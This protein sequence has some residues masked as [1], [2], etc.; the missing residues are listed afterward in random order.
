MLT[1]ARLR[2]VPHTPEQFDAYAGFWGKDP[3]HFLRSLAPMRPEDA[4]T[5]LLRHYGHW[6]AF[7]YG[8]FLGYDENDVLVAEVGFVDFRRAV[9][10]RFDGVPEAMWKIDLGRQGQGLAT[11]AMAAIAPWYDA[12]RIAPRSVC[13]IDP[14]NSPSIRVAERLGFV[15]FERTLYRD[16]PIVLFERPAP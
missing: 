9:G 2:L 4:W 15:E 10:P 13:M 1:T 3:G 7:G 16:A 5:R 11:E 12:Q 8:P 6:T 14:A